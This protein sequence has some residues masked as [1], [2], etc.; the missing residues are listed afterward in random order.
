MPVNCRYCS[1]RT[2]DQTQPSGLSI[3]SGPHVLSV[4]QIR[5]RIFRAAALR[6]HAAAGDQF[7][8]HLTEQRAPLVHRRRAA[9]GVDRPVGRVAAE[10]FGQLLWPFGEQIAE[11][12]FAVRGHVEQFF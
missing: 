5:R 11:P 8:Q 7:A 1:D 6:L 9:F 3:S 10:R 4:A 12:A 2:W